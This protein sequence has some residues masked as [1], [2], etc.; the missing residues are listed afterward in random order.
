MVE[1]VKEHCKHKDCVYRGT[2]NFQPCCDYIL[3]EKHS[4]GCGISDCDKYRT[5][6]RKIKSEYNYFSMEIDDDV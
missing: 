5:G 6:K 1:T 2:V 3:F 4:R